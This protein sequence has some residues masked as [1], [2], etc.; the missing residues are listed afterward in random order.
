MSTPNVEMQK[1][2]KICPKAEL[3][4]E[5]GQPAVFLP[6]LKVKHAGTTVPVDAILM[7][8]YHSGYTTRLFL[9]KPFSNR[10]QNWTTHTVAGTTWYAMSW[11][12]VAAS[13]GWEEILAAHLGPLQ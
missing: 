3:W 13:L 2:R 1:M 7:P 5:G 12:G 8:G 11:N 6:G 10:G 4:Q 9:K